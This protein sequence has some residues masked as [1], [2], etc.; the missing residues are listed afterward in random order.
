MS[1]CLVVLF[2]IGWFIFILYLISARKKALYQQFNSFSERFGGT[3]PE[4]QGI[5]VGLP[6][7]DTTYNRRPLQISMR[8]S[9]G[10]HKTT[11]SRFDMN[12]HDINFEFVITQQDFLTNIG[13]YLGMQDIEIDDY[14]FDQAFI[15]KTN[16]PERFK[17]IFDEEI[18]ADLISAVIE[19][20]GYSLRLSGGRLSYE[21]IGAFQSQTFNSQFAS[22]IEIAVKIA[23][24]IDGQP[25]QLIE[26]SSSAEI[27][28]PPVIAQ[29]ATQPRPTWND[30]PEDEQ[31]L[32]RLIRDLPDGQFKKE[33]DRCLYVIQYRRRELVLE[34]FYNSDPRILN[35]SLT[36]TQKFWLR[37][38]PQTG[39]DTI[40]EIRVS[41][42]FVDRKFR[43]HSDQR[44]AARRFLESVSKNVGLSWLQLFERFEINKG[45]AMLTITDPKRQNFLRSALEQTLGNVL[46]L[47]QAYE[48]QRLAMSILQSASSE[49]ICPYCREDLDVEKEPIVTCKL[50]HTAHHQSCLNE[51]KQCTTWGCL[52]AESDFA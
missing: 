31:Y 45:R 8:Q 34:Y 29:I 17:E 18:H 13:K 43:I 51:N 9:G 47:L 3:L 46:N 19:S 7:F 40:D 41:D 42:S 44:E 38:L 50:C 36:V 24:R 5:L 32:K 10:K 1:G 49:N 12:V 23:E 52:A 14:A 30:W 2:F 35:I 15:I 16:L 28:V 27:P 39:D 11:Y 6:R 33:D 26:P 20:R 25:A 37:M 21:S 48:E 4:P 22:M